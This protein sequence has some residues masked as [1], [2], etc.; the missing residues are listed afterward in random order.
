MLAKALLCGQWYRVIG[1]LLGIIV[2][3]ARARQIWNKR[4]EPGERP[5]LGKTLAQYTLVLLV[6]V[7]L[8]P[9]LIPL[10]ILWEIQER[11]SWRY[12]E[13]RERSFAPKIRDLVAR[14]DIEAIEARELVSDPL[15]GAPRLPFGHLNLAWHNFI[16]QL[17]PDAQLWS[18]AVVW[19]NGFGGREQREGYVALRSGEIGLFFETLRYRLD[20]ELQRRQVRDASSRW[21]AKLLKLGGPRY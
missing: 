12:L 10:L 20:E 2:L 11:R 18:Y 13:K 7:L 9:L 21:V 5:P 1:L 17:P 8:W 4:S 19:K 3:G 16:A 6:T 15:G 14:L